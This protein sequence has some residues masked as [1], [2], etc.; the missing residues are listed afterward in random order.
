MAHR[1]RLRRYPFYAAAVGELELR[2]GNH[3]RARA[4][5]ATALTLARN[6]AERRFLERRLQACETI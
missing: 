6:K 4:D 2:R 5:F 1:E 3:D